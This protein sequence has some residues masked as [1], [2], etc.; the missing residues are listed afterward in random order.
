MVSRSGGRGTAGPCRGKSGLHRAGCWREPGGGDL[1]TK[2]NRERPPMDGQPSQVRVKRCGK[3]APACGATR[4]SGKLHP[5][6]G[7]A[8]GERPAQHLRVGR[9]DGWPPVREH[10]RIPLTDRLTIATPGQ[11]PYR[12]NPWQLH[13]NF[14][15]QHITR[16]VD[17]EREPTATPVGQWT[18][19]VGCSITP[20]DPADGAVPRSPRRGSCS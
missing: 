16:L 9:T 17:G 1:T 3:S 15:N 2:C 19:G 20:L 8:G 5:E 12:P 6:Q 10:H 11:S 18:A 7:Q 4:G 13:G 14:C